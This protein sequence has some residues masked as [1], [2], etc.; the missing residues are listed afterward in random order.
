VLVAARLD[1]FSLLLLYL[2]G[3]FYY[4]SKLLVL[5]FM[6]SVSLGLFHTLTPDFVLSLSIASAICSWRL[7]ICGGVCIVYLFGNKGSG[8]QWVTLLKMNGSGHPSD[9]VHLI[10]NAESVN[11]FQ[12]T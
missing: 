1:L 7:R 11:D 5:F 2:D 6:L 8:C 9:Q 10:R 4:E 12:F 3:A